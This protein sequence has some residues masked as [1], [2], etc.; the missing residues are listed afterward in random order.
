MR[1]QYIITKS[2]VFLAALVAAGC[3]KS[4]SGPK[5]RATNSQQVS[6]AP[7][8]M[9]TKDFGEVEFTAQT[10]K[11]VSLGDGRDCVINPTVLAN[12]ALQLDMSVERK[13]GD[14]RIQ[15]LGQSRLTARPG[16]QCAISVGD[17][18][19]SLTPRLK[20]Q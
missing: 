6:S 8:D 9:P 3:S 17:T 15:R 4:S 20:A 13:G 19:V 5:V 11:R 1:I 12:G 18:M 14:G 2:A 10:P 7:A 16:Q